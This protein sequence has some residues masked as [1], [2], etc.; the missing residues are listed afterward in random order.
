MY[1][2]HVCTSCVCLCVCVSEQREFA[3]LGFRANAKVSKE[4]AEQQVRGGREGGA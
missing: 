1:V 4:A 3:K 2:P